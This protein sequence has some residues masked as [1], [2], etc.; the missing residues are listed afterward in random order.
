MK[1]RKPVKK[2]SVKKPTKKAAPRAARKVVHAPPVAAPV[3]V[4]PK[5]LK[6]IEAHGTAIKLFV[7]A[8]PRQIPTDEQRLAIARRLNEVGHLLPKYIPQGE[9]TMRK[10]SGIPGVTP[11]QIIKDHAQNLKDEAKRLKEKA[12]QEKAKAKADAAKLKQEAAQKKKMKTADVTPKVT[13]KEEPTPKKGAAKPAPAPTKAVAQGKKGK[14][15]MAAGKVPPGGFNKSNRPATSGELIRARI[16][17]HK[18]T[19]EQIAAEVRKL[20]E[21]RNTSVTDVR[22]NRGQMRKAGVSAPDPVGGEPQK[23]RGK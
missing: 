6:E 3:A 20:F 11:A 13:V 22:W 9:H 17:E 18:L 21:G 12:A 16:V 23:A 15:S 4:V 10:S 2:A 14:Q 7:M 5:G 1:K 19:D 8:D